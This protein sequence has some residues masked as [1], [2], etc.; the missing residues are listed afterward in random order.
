MLVLIN[1]TTRDEYLRRKAKE[2]R[3][4]TLLRVD[5]NYRLEHFPAALGDALESR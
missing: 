3:M 5:F 4:Q 2:F 1:A